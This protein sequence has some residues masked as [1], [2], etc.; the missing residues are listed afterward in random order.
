MPSGTPL[1]RDEVVRKL[2]QIR[3]AVKNGEPLAQAQRE[4]GL[5]APTYYRWNKRWGHLVDGAT[6]RKDNPGRP[7]TIRAGAVRGRA[8]RMFKAPDQVLPEIPL[9]LPA[10][11]TAADW[12]GHPSEPQAA[13]KKR[14][15]SRRRLHRRR[16]RAEAVG[17]GPAPSSWGHVPPER[18]LAVHRENAVLRDIVIDQMI[19]INQLR[20]GRRP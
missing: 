20:H 1:N 19:E 13:A 18:R 10:R 14:K 17:H 12:L 11:A 2:R 5:S 8:R 6:G 15:P 16:P 4:A 3:Q 9:S 7:K